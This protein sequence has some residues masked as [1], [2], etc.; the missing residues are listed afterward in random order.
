MI[1]SMIKQLFDKDNTYALR[2][3][4]MLMIIASHTP[5]ETD[6]YF[7][8]IL[9][10]LGFDYWGAFGTGLFFLLSG[11]GMFLSLQ[12]TKELNLNYFLGKIKKLFIPFFYTWIIYL[13]LFFILDI[14]KFNI[15]L[16]VDFITLSLPLGIDAWFFK[17]IL[18]LYIIIILLFKIPISHR[19]KVII[20]SMIVCIYYITFKELSFGPWWYNTVLNFPL[21]MM[22]AWSKDKMNNSYFSLL[23]ILLCFVFCYF[24]TIAFFTY[25]CF[26]LCALWFVRIIN[27]QYIPGLK[28]IGTNS[29]FYYL[30]QCPLFECFEKRLPSL[31]C[32]FTVVMMTTLLTLLYLR[33]EKI[34]ISKKYKKE[35][36][37]T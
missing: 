1:I 16:I 17:V 31:L 21:G 5:F 12:R 14:S 13:L 32:F 33:I 28:F 19:S 26:S 30:L 6:N 9:Q 29:I 25:I 27:I 18:A 3:I 36:A 23:I 11:Y 37:G 22:F 2:G 7:Y 10:F 20:M 15:H 24:T 34:I 4:C 35:N 8:S